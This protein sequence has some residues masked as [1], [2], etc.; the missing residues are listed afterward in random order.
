[1][2]ADSLWR[3][4]LGVEKTVV[5]DVV[6][7]RVGL[8]VVVSVRPVARE[9]GRCGRCRRRCSGYD[10]GRG[11]RR[12]WRG[13]DLG[14]VRLFVEAESVR[15]ACPEH[16]VVVAHVPWA[17]H[18]AGH[19]R[20]FDDQV[21]WLATQT[22]K[23]AVTQLM[24]ISWRTVGAI[25]KR[26]CADVDAARDRLDGLARVGIDEVSYRKGQQY[27]TVVVDHNSGDLVWAQPGRDAATV[28]RF[29]DALGPDRAEALTH[30]SADGASWI[31]GVVAKQAPQAV[32]CADP[33]HLVSWAT[34]CLDEVRRETWNIAR[35]AAGGTRQ[36]GD[37]AGGRYHASRGD[38]QTIARSRWALWK[39]PED[40]TT[41]QTA[42]LAWIATSSPRLH[43]A[44]LLK[45]G[46]RH[47]FKLGGTDGKHALQ[48]WLT[49]VQRCRIDVF[50]E[51]GRR[52]KRHLPAIHASLDHGLTNARVEAVN[53][54]IRLI[55]RTAYGFKDPQALIALAM[56]TLG[57]YRPPLPGRN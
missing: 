13:L 45:E 28:A 29:F 42:Q 15:V 53:T 4:V 12:R 11:E 40:L 8:V 6:F 25:V 1:M 26:V 27:L 30:V 55:T 39:N 24:R 21:A 56:L 43:R 48:R 51:L 20:M 46:L 14:V 36:I 3:A 44:Y 47:V 37:L 16:G 31:T 17:R 49:W 9:R 22:S 52:I 50:V 5:E 32:L 38:A 57:G 2:R 18:D 23:T 33:F 34:K 54:K 10:L 41:K 19:T 35:R 7:D